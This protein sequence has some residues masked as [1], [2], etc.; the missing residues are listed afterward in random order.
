[1]LALGIIACGSSA[2][3]REGTGSQPPPSKPVRSGESPAIVTFEVAGGERFRARLV[4]SSAI[5]H[6]RALLEGRAADAPIPIGVVIFN[7][8]GTDDDVNRGHRWHL[9]PATFEFA[10]V[11]TEACDGRPSDVDAHWTVHNFCPWSARVVAV[12]GGVP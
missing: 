7:D 8:N 2:G 6:A 4:A 1:M 3:A 9:D 5:A 11:A 10:D 12:D